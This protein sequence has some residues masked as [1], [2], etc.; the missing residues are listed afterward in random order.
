MKKIVFDRQIS[1]LGVKLFDLSFVNFGP[2]DLIGK[3][4]VSPSMACRFHVVACV[5]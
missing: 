2:P 4:P 5:G 3:Y 1:D